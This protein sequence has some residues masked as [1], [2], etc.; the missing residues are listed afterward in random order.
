MIMTGAMVLRIIRIQQEK[1]TADQANEMSKLR[2]DNQRRFVAML[3][4]EFRNPL[5]GIDRTA[6]L[7]QAMPEQSVQDINKRLGGIRT[8]VGRLNTLVDSF[9]MSES[10]DTLALKPS[11]AVVNMADYLRERQQ[12]VSPE[13]QVRIRTDLQPAQ[14]VANIDK[15]LLS[16]AI[17]NLLDNAL[18]YAPNDTPVTLSARSEQ[19]DERRWLIMEVS[20]EGAG[21]PEAELAMLGTPYYRAASAMGHQGTGLGYHFCQQIAQAHGG[22]L[23]ARN[24]EGGGLVV[25]IRLPQ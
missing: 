1:N 12:A 18:R 13:Q 25:T 6:N 10:A 15:R 22:S 21:V 16:L 11:L 5:A 17:Q 9:L 24:R 8:Q 23:K 4:H 2:M 14:L 20:D 19:T 3:T 7:L